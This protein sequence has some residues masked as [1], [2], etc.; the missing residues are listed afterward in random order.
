MTQQAAI[1]DIIRTIAKK[2]I[3][4]QPDE[5]LFDS[6]MLDSFTLPDLV[7]AIEAGFGISVPDSD[8]NPRQFDTVA[9]IQSYIDKR[10]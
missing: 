3:S 6:G 2:D 5:S 10:R 9:R 7:M 4:P 1:L 8:L